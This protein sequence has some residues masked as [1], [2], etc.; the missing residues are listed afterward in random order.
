MAKVK[1]R[2]SETAAIAR[3]ILCYFQAVISSENTEIKKNNI[4]CEEV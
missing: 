1:A 4:S 2:I 3:A